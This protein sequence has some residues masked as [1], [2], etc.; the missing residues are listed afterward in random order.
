MHAVMYMQYAYDK[1]Y[2]NNGNKKGYVVLTQNDVH[3]ILRGELAYYYIMFN[4]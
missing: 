3:V 4:F 2:A 1:E